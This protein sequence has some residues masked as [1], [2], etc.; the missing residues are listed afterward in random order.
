MLRRTHQPA[1]SLHHTLAKRLE[2]WIQSMS[3]P[4]AADPNP[5]QLEVDPSWSLFDQNSIRIA[6]EPFFQQ[7]HLHA[8]SNEDSSNDIPQSNST[9]GLQDHQRFSNTEPWNGYE[10]PPDT[11][12]TNLLRLFGNAEYQLQN[13]MGGN[14]Q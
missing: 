3:S 10:H 14:P 1:P 2:N 6:S 8:V 11:W 12:P 5:S 13:N 7:N 4:P 9:S